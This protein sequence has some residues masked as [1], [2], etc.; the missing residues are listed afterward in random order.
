MR[1]RSQAQTTAACLI[2]QPLDQ[3]HRL[4]LPQAPVAVGDNSRRPFIQNRQLG[5]GHDLTILDCLDVVRHSHDA[6]RVVTF[7]V[8]IDQAR[9]NKR[10]LVFRGAAGV[11]QLSCERFEYRG[12][13]RGHM[14]RL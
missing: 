4:H 2:D 10:C 3:P 6:V 14:Q 12:S 7:Q 13:Y 9:R 8:G 1:H 11:K 5:A